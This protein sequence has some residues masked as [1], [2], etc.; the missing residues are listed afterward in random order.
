MSSWAL[1]GFLAEPPACQPPGTFHHSF[2]DGD[3]QLLWAELYRQQAALDG[4]V[5]INT[6]LALDGDGRGEQIAAQLAD[7]GE[8]M[9]RRLRRV[10]LPSC[11][12]AADRSSGD[13]ETVLATAYDESGSI[14]IWPTGHPVSRM[15]LE[16]ELAHLAGSA[17]SV[18]HGLR[19]QWHAAR[20]RDQRRW[21]RRRSPA[22]WLMSRHAGPHVNAVFDGV[23][24]RQLDPGSGWCS[25]YAAAQADDEH[26]L[27]EDWAEAV[28][29]YLYAERH[30]GLYVHG[31]VLVR[32]SLLYPHRRRL[33]RRWLKDVPRRRWRLRRRSADLGHLHLRWMMPAGHPDRAHGTLRIFDRRRRTLR[34]AGPSDG[35]CSRRCE[36]MC[37]W[38]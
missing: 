14:A 22:V 4:Q 28:A 3:E 20:R 24:N 38:A 2:W 12:Q 26:K 34:W 35:R 18:P 15:V 36:G 31:R 13:G 10:M 23:M 16:H 25:S 8:R 11:A 19:D 1:T 32:F 7:M 33:I 6:A 29:L 27:S 17:G 37:S 21:Q 5:A 30:G 9:T